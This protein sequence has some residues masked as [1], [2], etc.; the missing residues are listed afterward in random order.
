LSKKKLLITGASGFIGYGAVLYFA[1]LSNYEVIAAVRKIPSNAAFPNNVRILDQLDIN[2]ESA[3]LS[4]MVGVDYVLH[5]AARYHISKNPLTDVL[6]L[7]RKI[8]VEG[9]MRIA[10]AAKASGVKRFIF[11]S[12]LKVHGEENQLD[13][14][15]RETDI[16]RP[17]YAYGISKQEAEEKL[18][19]LVQ[20]SA[21]ELVIIRPPPVYGPRV[22]ANFLAMLNCIKWGLPIPLASVKTLR[23]YVAL[24]NLLELIRISADH[25]KAAGEIFLVSDQRNWAIAD[26]IT[27]LASAMDR[28]AKLFP[29]PPIFLSWLA[30]LIGKKPLIDLLIMPSCVDSSKARK[31]LQ[32][33]PVIESEEA[34]KQTA[35]DYLRFK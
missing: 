29:F 9:S 19:E 16:L 4:A 26:L 8:N 24:D 6:A 17:K 10:R 21:M 30:R 32:W 3:W 12:S 7:C 14:P 35:Q 28:P 18:T 1:K 27:Q 33:M 20:D 13:Q 31:L 34:L 5:C 2:H 25:P 22:P 15:F 11:L 23:S